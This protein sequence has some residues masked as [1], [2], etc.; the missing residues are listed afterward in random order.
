MS[1]TPYLS[2]LVSIRIEDIVGTETPCRAVRIE[3]FSLSLLVANASSVRR[4]MR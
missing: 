1:I 4:L 2:G 3:N